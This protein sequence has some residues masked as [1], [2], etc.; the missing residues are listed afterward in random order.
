M[1]FGDIGRSYGGCGGGHG[2][3]GNVIVGNSSNIGGIDVTS[4][5]GGDGG[6]VVDDTVELVVVVVGIKMHKDE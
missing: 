4:I 6:N 1:G 5:V 2:D 3:G